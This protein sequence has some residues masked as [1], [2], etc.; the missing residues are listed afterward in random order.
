MSLRIEAFAQ[1]VLLVMASEMGVLQAEEVKP[2]AW[3][4]QYGY[5]PPGDLRTHAA[6]SPKSITTAIAAMQRFYGLTITG[7]IDDNTIKAMKKPRCGVPDKFGTELKSNLRKKR[8]VHQGLKWDK[9][10]LTFCI[11][12]Y[13]PKVGEYETHEAIRKAFQVWESVSPLRF[14]EIPYS[15]IRDKVVDFAD[16]ML[17]FA[18]GFHGDSSPFDGEGGFLAHAYFPGN[19]IGGDTHFD[20]AEP[21]TVGNTDLSGNDVFLVSVHELGHALGLEH[22]NDPSAIMAPFYQ[23]MD[24]ENFQ[25]PEDDLKGI[26]QIYGGRSGPRPPPPTPQSPDHPPKPTHTS[27]NPRIGPDICEGHF[28]TIAILRGEM[29][30]FKD[31]W[32]WRIRNNVVLEGYPMPIGHLWRGLPSNINAAY[33]RDDGDFVFFKGDRYWVFK[34]FVVEDGYPKTLKEMGSGLPRDKIDS[35]LFF[36]PTG[37][38]YFFR[39]NKY[40]RYNED[41]RSVDPDYPKSISVWQGVPDNI[42]ASIMS[43]DQ[44]HTYFYKANKYWKFNN[45]NLRVEPGYPKSALKDWM[46][47]SEDPETDGGR[48]GGGADP[49]DKDRDETE[50]IIIKV[51]EAGSSGGAGAA[52]VVV[53]LMLLV[54]VVLVLGALLFFRRYGTPRRLLYC[55]RSLL[56]KV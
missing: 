54:C 34:E 11:Q 2:E 44:G 20:S 9:T 55:Q 4:Q 17:F 42:K 13:T 24:T 52:A 22:S 21:W 53:P 6:R 10:D 39:G 19:G 3:L 50:V 15:H 5:L 51:E 45:Q 25:L 18:D 7:S 1:L 32:F 26:Q 29:F 12:N 16:I 8:Y 49:E 40:Y 41:S 43:R 33:E 47:C 36:N 31:K 37:Q 38:T 30:V 46:G 56:D 27:Y 23:W 35:A 14:R 28:D 48:G